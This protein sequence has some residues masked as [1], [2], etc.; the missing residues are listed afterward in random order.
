MCQ[1]PQCK[2]DQIKIA[3]G[4]L[5]QGTLVMINENQSWR[6]RHWYAGLSRYLKALLI[7]ARGCVTP[8][9]LH[10]WWDKAEKNME[11]IDGFDE[12][13]EEVQPKVQRA[14]EASHVDDEDWNGVSI[15][16]VRAST[17][18]NLFLGRRMQPL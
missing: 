11:L 10:N 2:T 7:C 12:L 6:W 8:T 14:L 3:K 18:A 4:E 9:V 13:P 5:R 16:A 1:S 15:N 17:I